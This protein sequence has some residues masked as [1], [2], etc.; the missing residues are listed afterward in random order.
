MSTALCELGNAS[1][2]LGRAINVDGRRR[3]PRATP[4]QAML[5]SRTYRKPWK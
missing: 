4:R 5:L 1:L 3:G 2:K